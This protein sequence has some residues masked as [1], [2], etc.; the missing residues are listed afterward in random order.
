M[1]PVSGRRTVARLGLWS[2]PFNA[3]DSP[4]AIIPSVRYVSRMSKCLISKQVN[5]ESS[6]SSFRSVLC[7]ESYFDT[8]WIRNGLVLAKQ[9]VAVSFVLRLASTTI[10]R[11]IDRSVRPGLSWHDGC[12]RYSCIS[13]IHDKLAFHPT[14]ALTV[15]ATPY[16]YI[17]HD[18]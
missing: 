13:T 2:L 15:Q 3:A 14:R 5:I 9:S 17:P 16:R 12:F 18:G 6:T 8:N 1:D 7:N 4:S 10:D 11:S